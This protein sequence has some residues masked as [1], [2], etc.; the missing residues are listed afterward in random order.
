[1][2]LTMITETELNVLKVMAAII[3]QKVSEFSFVWCFLL[4]K[5]RICNFGKNTTEVMLCTCSVYLIRRIQWQCASLLVM[6]TSI[7]WLRWF[8]HCRVTTFFF[9]VNY[10]VLWGHTWDCANIPF[11]FSLYFIASIDDSCLEP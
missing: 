6:L 5:C 11:F 10:S 9:A 4:I 2:R 1:M 7:T 3:L 8:L